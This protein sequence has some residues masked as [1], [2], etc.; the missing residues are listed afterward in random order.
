MARS[1]RKG[2]DDPM[3]TIYQRIHDLESNNERGSAFVSDFI[4]HYQH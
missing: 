2:Q 4:D 1:V 3:Q